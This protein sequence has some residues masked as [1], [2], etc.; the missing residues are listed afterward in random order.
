MATL[1]KQAST[2]DDWLHE[3]KFDGYR[4]LCA[5]GDGKPR[6]ITRNGHDWTR[7]FPRV[8]AA[9][10]A[11]SVRE[12]WLDGELVAM[13]SSGASDFQTLQNA[14]R[15]GADADL[16]YYLFDLP[17]CDGYDLTR[18]PLIERKRL[19][20]QLL[21]S[22]D[23]A[24]LRYS[25]HMEGEGG[26][27]YAHACSHALEGIISKRADSAYQSRR[28]RTWVMVKCARSQEFV[29]CGYTDPAGAREYFGALLLAY[30]D[31]DGRLVY[32]GRVGTGFNAQSLEAVDELLAAR[33][34]KTSPLRELP[35]NFDKRGVHWVRPDV[36]VEATFANWTDDGLLRQ[37]SFQGVRED[38]EPRDVVREQPAAAH[39]RPASNSPAAASRSSAQSKTEAVSDSTSEQ[40]T[41]AGQQ[42]THPDRILYPEQGVTKRDLAQFYEHIADW[43]LPHITGRPLSVV[44]CPQGRPR[45]CFF[46]KHVTES[47]P[48]A[49]RGVPVQEK[50]KR[51]TYITIGGL[52]GLIALV[53]LGVLEIHPWGARADNLEKPDR[54]VFD[55]DPGPELGWAQVIEGARMV[56]ER[57]GDLGL[58]SFVK[59]SGGK[60]LHVVVPVARRTGWDNFRAFAK[61][62]AQDAARH[63]PQRYVATMSK[64]KRRGRIFIDW[65]RNGRGATSVAAYST[66]ARATAPVSTL[67]SWDELDTI[68]GP[69][70]FTLANLPQRLSTLKTDPWSGFFETRQS[71][72]ISMLK[73]VRNAPPAWQ[74][75]PRPRAPRHRSRPP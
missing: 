39:A 23:T 55:L 31:P 33:N 69:A 25:D 4:L 37:A 9:A 36:V 59:T 15:Q 19:L 49:I 62:V 72:T 68:E 27:M 28:T 29:V 24:P 66:R 12:A 61:A 64:A 38:K 26:R 35:K 67:L 14:L 10:A 56:R 42:L 7:K 46:Q 51:S 20:R 58:R 75:V 3:I 47:L 60:G 74:P 17:Y 32:C 34:R 43:I 8:V 30:H 44:R 11:L 63:E 52:S 54:L 5:I 18:T 70:A 50:D 71:I 1:V 57:L 40:T 6:L 22:G 45:S 16:A 73:Q 48:D 53:Q 65:L 2:G 21:A 13:K 41:I